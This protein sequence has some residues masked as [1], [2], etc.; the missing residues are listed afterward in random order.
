MM[1]QM[2]RNIIAALVMLLAF[3]IIA[4]LFLVPIP[5]T[6][7]EVALVIL[8]VAVGWAGNV[9][10]YHFGTS[11]GSTRKTDIMNEKRF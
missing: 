9:V 4:G 3:G 8:G 1:K 11:E 2:P 7:G 5:Q 6:N 10:N